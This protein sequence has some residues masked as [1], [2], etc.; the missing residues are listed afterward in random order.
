MTHSTSSPFKRLLGE[1]TIL[2]Y[3]IIVLVPIS[4]VVLGAFKNAR[5]AAVLKLSLPTVW[6]F[7]NIISLLGNS[8]F[9]R[10]LLNSTVFVIFG[11]TLCILFSSMSAF[12]LARNRSRL[13]TFIYYLFISGILIP[14]F[15]IP[16]MKLLRQLQ[17]L[18]TYPGI[19][20][21]YICGNTPFA[22]FLLT[23]FIK[24]IPRALE[25][26]AY[27]DGARPVRAFFK[28]LFPL[29]TPV[30]VTLVVW[31]SLNMWN[32]F[33]GA[34]YFLK[35][36]S[37]LPITMWVYRN[38]TMYQIYWER[39]FPVILLSMIPLVVIYLAAQRYIISGLVAGSIKG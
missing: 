10:S 15:I 3:A 33:Q 31:L 28:I 30:V 36:K 20:L 35:S 17:L 11:V 14:P 12:Y 39:I 18:D 27:I 37:M 26:C 21:V 16:L 4:L 23:G 1:L 7:S 6:V 19:I 34:L 32:D 2:I 8:D 24:N 13:S 38:V 25:E 22:V 9:H 29:L 5:E